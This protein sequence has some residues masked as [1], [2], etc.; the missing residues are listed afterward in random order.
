MSKYTSM[1]AYFNLTK[2]K[3]AFVSWNTSPQSFFAIFIT[4]VIKI[5]L[6]A[7]LRLSKIKLVQSD[8][9]NW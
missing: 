5:L 7:L 3:N 4:H 1:L 6:L 2:A 8:P 9:S